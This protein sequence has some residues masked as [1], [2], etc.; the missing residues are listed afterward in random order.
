MLTCIASKSFAFTFIVGLVCA[1][2]PITYLPAHLFF[3]TQIYIRD[4]WAE[5]IPDYQ[6]AGKVVNRETEVLYF[7]R[8]IG[9]KEHL[10][11]R[12]VYKHAISRIIILIYKT[13]NYATA[14]SD[15]NL[16]LRRTKLSIRI[17]GYKK[18]NSMQHA[19]HFLAKVS[20]IS[21]RSYNQ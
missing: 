2:H 7:T 19:C 6:T 9:Y 16:R 5:K 12:L 10:P 4:K 13:A 14:F 1:R 3:V 20:I 15:I 11:C 18:M 8:K 21:F 17:M